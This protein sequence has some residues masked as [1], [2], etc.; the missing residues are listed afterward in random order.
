VRSEQPSADGADGADAAASLRNREA[1]ASGPAS[2]LAPAALEASPSAATQAIAN[3][4]PRP[5]AGAQASV[6]DNA[7]SDAADGTS[8]PNLAEPSPDA[9][10][11]PQSVI[12]RTSP[13]S[14][15]S[16][17][18]RDADDKRPTVERPATEAESPA[19]V[20]P[21]LVPLVLRWALAPVNAIGRLDT[22]GL[23]ALVFALTG[24]ALAVGLALR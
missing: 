1:A 20:W 17:S 4:E 5:A 24:I 2:N 21:G 22:L 3:A 11:R 8:E 19:R 16:A 6:H 14:I 10:D 23:G 12:V 18:T 15:E 7:A 9:D 13:S